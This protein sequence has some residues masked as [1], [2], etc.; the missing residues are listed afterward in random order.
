MCRQIGHTFTSLAGYGILRSAF[1]WKLI[2]VE[3]NKITNTA[4]IMFVA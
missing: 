3:E 4:R 1:F 2:T